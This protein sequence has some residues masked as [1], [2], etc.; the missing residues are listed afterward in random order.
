MDNA[1]QRW[2]VPLVAVVV[3]AL[4]TCVL[5]AGVGGALFFLQR[6]ANAYSTVL[7][8]TDSGSEAADTS[9]G[10]SPQYPETAPLL[11]TIEPTGHELETI[12]LLAL[13]EVPMR[14]PVE[15]AM[16]LGGVDGP[17]QRAAP[18]VQEELALDTPLQFWVQDVRTTDFFSPTAR[19]AFKT[20]HAYW[21]VEEGYQLDRDNLS[22]S[23]WDFEQRTYPTNRRIFGSEWNPGVDGD[24]HIYIFL[25]N[26]PGVGGYFS[27]PD[28]YPTQVTHY[29]NAHEMFYINLNNAGPGSDYFDG[30]LAHEFQHMIHWAVDRNEETWV[31]EGLS[32]LAAQLNGV[33]V[34]GSEW[35]YSQAPDTQLN[36]WPDLED[37]GSNYGASYLFL[38]YFLERYGEE[39]VR[40]LVAHPADG[41]AGFDAVLKDVEQADTSFTELFADWVV[42]NYL[43]DPDVA[44]GRYGYRDVWMPEVELAARH[45]S[46]P[47]G[48][49]GEVHE[50][51]SDYVLLD[52][53]GDITIEFTG[54]Q[55]VSLL[56]N[57]VYSGEYQWWSNRGDDGDATLTRAFDLSGL[58]DAT[59]RVWMWYDLEPDYDYAYVQASADG[60]QTWDLLENEFT[61]TENPTGS[62]YGP[63]LNGTSGRGRHAEWVQQT[64]D[65]RAYV[66][67]EVLVRF[68]VITDESV[69]RPG[70]ALD[71]IS[72]PELGYLDDAENDAGGWDARGWVR[73]TDRVPQEWLVQVITIGNE[74]QVRR[75]ALDATMSGRMTIAGL[76]RNVDNAIVVISGV[77]PV[78]TEMAAYSYSVTRE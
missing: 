68:E 61:T 19:L 53:R 10:S 47:D 58:N 67:G 51:G 69:H 28:E 31:T 27:G 72:I 32:Q 3:I 29:S 50:F 78:T 16:R 13:T 44:G 22:R 39:A 23:A 62:S 57:E 38:S 66:G 46:Y 52:G 36:A 8:P 7:Q 77:T 2:L 35:L 15:L 11:D 75:L 55:A 40:Q 74:I 14:D 54:S 70:L 64:F 4:G 49:Q 56:G 60:G 34:G 5:A 12:E 26:V 42:A 43:D 45:R 6:F 1:R 71:D 30:I 41:I 21:W 48:D 65:L 76:G 17:I 37:A 33:E 20:D 73:V 59:L 9:P 24:P 18:E 63:A 25:G